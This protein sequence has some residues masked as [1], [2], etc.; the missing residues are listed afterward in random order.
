MARAPNLLESICRARDYTDRLLGA[1]STADWFRMPQEGVSH[2]AWQV[3]HLAFAQYSLAL[4][5]VRGERPDDEQ[6]FPAA[7]REKFGRASTPVA[8]PKAYPSAEE[9]RRIFDAVHRR[10]VEETSAL[11]DAV[12]DEATDAPHGRFST[13]GGALTWCAEHEMMHAGQIGLLRRLV[14]H[15]PIW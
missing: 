1:T 9:I 14:G 13:K 5:W 12:L 4:R 3:G 10:V 15:G 6:L 11:G 7:L 2:I 8:D